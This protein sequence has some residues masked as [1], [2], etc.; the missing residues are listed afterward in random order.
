[1]RLLVKAER[2]APLQTALARWEAQFRYPGE[3]RLTI[4]IDP[5]SFM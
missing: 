2:A 1:V 5:Q 4:D 3:L